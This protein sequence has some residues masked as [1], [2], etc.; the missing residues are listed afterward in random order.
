MIAGWYA[1]CI[2]VFCTAC[3]YVEPVWENQPPVIVTPPNTDSEIPVLLGDGAIV[4]QVTAY[5][6]DDDDVE[7]VWRTPPSLPVEE[8]PLP[9][10]VYPGRRE[11]RSMLRFDGLDATE[12]ML[13]VARAIDVNG[14]SVTVDWIL[15]EP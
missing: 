10:E 9:I 12:G 13:I 3:P 5:D 7:F 4:L 14:E 2:A 15:E 8:Y 1:I 6:P 11:F